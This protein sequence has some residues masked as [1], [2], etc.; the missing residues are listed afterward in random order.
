MFNF[1]HIGHYG[2]SGIRL[3]PEEKCRGKTKIKTSSYGVGE[4]SVYKGLSTKTR[5]E[6]SEKNIE[7]VI[8]TRRKIRIY[9]R[10]YLGYHTTR[11][12]YDMPMISKL[13]SLTPL[14]VWSGGF[15]SQVWV[16][17]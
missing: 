1:T 17:S 8:C 11:C 12:T 4:L 9:L 15:L 10:I 7:K 3:I 13:H 16:E 5:R 2:W 14:R 6:D